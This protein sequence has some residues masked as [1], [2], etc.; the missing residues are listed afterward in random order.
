MNKKHV[1]Y[2]ICLIVPFT[3]AAQKALPDFSV[4]S[5]NKG[6][7]QI[8][9]VNPYNN[10]CIQLMVQRSYDSLKFFKT[11][12]T[13]QSPQLPQNGYID[14]GVM[15][16]VKTFY[17]IF[18]VL[19]DNNY[20]FTKSKIPGIEE[21]VITENIIPKKNK[22][23]SST[24]ETYANVITETTVKEKIDSEEVIE[25]LPNT[26]K[27]PTDLITSNNLN[28]KNKIA[29]P[30]VKPVEKKFISVYKA[31]KDSFLMR[32]EI[33]EYKK[34]RDSIVNNTKDTLYFLNATEVLIKPFY[35]KPV[36][37][38]SMYVFTDDR[39][40]VNIQL[41]LTKQHHYKIIFTD[42]SGLAVFEIKHVKEEELFLDKVNFIHAGWFNF[43]L[44]E[45]EKIKEKNKVFISKEF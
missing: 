45:D 10:N 7:V 21:A 43:E 12:F 9:W 27:L 16:G 26:K 23:D 14:N 42:S 1:F 25:A 17:R 30:V 44:F 32:F 4:R 11:I 20:F 36:W 37:K 38:P 19:S 35:V 41:P 8:S 15:A 31:S 13:A 18:Y 5:M 22:P 24:R 3:L 39:G 29:A 2:F 28:I 6:K 40:Y 34:F 33:G